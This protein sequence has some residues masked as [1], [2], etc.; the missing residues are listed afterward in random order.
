MNTLLIGNDFHA[1]YYTRKELIKELVKLHNVYVAIPKKENNKLIEQLG[2]NV[3]PLEMSRM[4]MNVFCELKVLF[5][6]N[7]IIK[8][9]KPNI[10]FTFTIKPNIYVGLLQRKKESC[11]I[12]TIT[13]LGRLFQ[14]ESIKKKLVIALYRF[15]F[16]NVKRIFFENSEIEEIFAK[17]NIAEN[18]HT[19]VNGA[20]VNLQ[21]N[22]LEEYPEDSNGLRIV[23]V[24]RI[25]R[26]KGFC[27]L[28]EA[29]Q[30]YEKSKLNLK[31]IVLGI[32]E[33]SFEKEFQKMHIPSNLILEGWQMDVHSYLK[34]AH[35]I[36]LPS[37]HEGMANVLL[38][39]AATGRPILASRIHGCIESFDEGVSGF[40][41]EKADTEDML[42][43]IDQ[44]TKLTNE[45]RCNMGRQGRK[46]ME[47][48]FNR[49]LVVKSFIEQMH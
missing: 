15:A 36:I 21:E 13:G 4:G 5:A 6:I 44:F 1:I 3:I 29:A 31:F 35:A 40:G 23:F 8:K 12:V 18:R 42:R 49:N 46:K 30:F 11:Q 38:E 25:E 48:E 33:K 34:S 16:S 27:E 32:C 10:I 2:C 43:A 39:A 19:I 14:K 47:Q 17:L 41:F 7:E 45:E 28:L 24:G 22:L 9:I 20:G 26:D 37:Y